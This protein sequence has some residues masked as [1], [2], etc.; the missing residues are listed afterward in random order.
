MEDFNIEEMRGELKSM[1]RARG[2]SMLQL[3]K[4]MNMSYQTIRSFVLGEKSPAY[5][6]LCLI[7]KYLKTY[8]G[9][10]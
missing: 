7:E 3:S 9:F 8:Q 4:E 10:K 5:T 6:T 2:L 1:R